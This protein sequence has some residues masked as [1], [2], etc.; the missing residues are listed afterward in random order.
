VEPHAGKNQLVDALKNHSI[1]V[2][3]SDIAPRD[4]GIVQSD[5]LWA[6]G[7]PN[8]FITGIVM[9]PPYQNIDAHIEKAL[10]LTEP[11]QGQVILL[12]RAELS[13]AKSRHHLFR[14]CHAF[15]AK[16]ELTSRPRWIEGTNGSPRHNYAWYVWDWRESGSGIKWGERT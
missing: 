1:A 8:E 9:N 12:A 2:Y 13:Y 6:S 14:G 15:D 11:V 16:V 7:L 10:E 3:A 4:S 5:F